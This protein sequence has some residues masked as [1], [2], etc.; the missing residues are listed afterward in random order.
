M[1][2]PGNIFTVLDTVKLVSV[3]SAEAVNVSCG[4]NIVLVKKPCS[5]CTAVS[6]PSME[7]IPNNGA[8]PLGMSRVIIAEKLFLARSWV[9][10]LELKIPVVI[11][12]PFNDL[13]V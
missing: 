8:D 6:S 1:I 10:L 11:L 3:A 13:D 4:N 12:V 9:R 2:I 7:V 5:V